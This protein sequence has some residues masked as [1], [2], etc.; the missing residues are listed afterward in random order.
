MLWLSSCGKGWEIY[1]YLYPFAPEMSQIWFNKTH[2]CFQ[3]S[4]SLCLIPVFQTLL[5]SW[6]IPS[7]PSWSL[8]AILSFDPFPFSTCFPSMSC[9]HSPCVP[10]SVTFFHLLHS[11]ASFLS[12]LSVN[13]S[14][15]AKCS[16]ASPMA[17]TQPDNIKRSCP[18]QSSESHTADPPFFLV[19]GRLIDWTSR[20]WRL[21]PPFTR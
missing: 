6:R 4:L 18:G 3:P 20:R 15:P 16:D 17:Q 9:S 11:F 8:L 10:I 19:I 5:F 13:S 12:T 14:L 1:P 7:T 2:L 21:P